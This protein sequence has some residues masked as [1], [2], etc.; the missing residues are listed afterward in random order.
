MVFFLQEKKKRSGKEK[1][2]H[3]QWG[4]TFFF[5]FRLQLIFPW[6]GLYKKVTRHI[7]RGRKKKKKGEGIVLCGHKLARYAWALFE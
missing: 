6:S 1:N 2:N 4:Y 3:Y 7:S 5:F